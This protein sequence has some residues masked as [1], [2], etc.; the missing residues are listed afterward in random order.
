[1]ARGLIAGWVGPRRCPFE[2]PVFLWRVGGGPPAGFRL[3]GPCWNYRVCPGVSCLTPGCL[4]GSISKV[5]TGPTVGLLCEWIWPAAQSAPAG[6]RAITA[7][8]PQSA[9]GW[10]GI[11]DCLEIRTRFLL[12]LRPSHAYAALCGLRPIAR[13]LWPIANRT[14][15]NSNLEFLIAGAV[16]PSCCAFLCICGLR[17]QLA[18]V[19]MQAGPGGGSILVVIKPNTTAESFTTQR[20]SQR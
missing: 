2:G 20:H 14:G 12:M 4:F 19:H 10:P 15:Q 18:I 7:F 6:V 1:M 5:P 16:L 17:M 8:A 3:R 13:G 11:A 9:G